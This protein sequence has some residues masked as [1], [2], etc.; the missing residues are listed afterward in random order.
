MHPVNASP[1][2]R[3]GMDLECLDPE[4]LCVCSRDGEDWWGEWRHEAEEGG[5]WT[6]GII[7][8]GSST[9]EQ[10][11]AS[12]SQTILRE[13]AVYELHQVCNYTTVTLLVG[14]KTHRHPGKT[15]E[16]LDSTIWDRFWMKL[17]VLVAAIR[18]CPGIHKVRVRNWHYS[19]GGACPTSEWHRLP[20]VWLPLV[21]YENKMVDLCGINEVYCYHIA[22]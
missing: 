18:V 17:A 10:N 6:E 3:M 2:I 13:R 22:N 14:K 4:T 20:V 19:E 16:D 12:K 7:T 1:H 5:W 9:K 8:G 15:Y 11:V 21:W